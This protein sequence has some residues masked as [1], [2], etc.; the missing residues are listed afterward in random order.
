MEMQ[1]AMKYGRK[2]ISGKGQKAIKYIVSIIF[3]CLCVVSILSTQLSQNNCMIFFP[4]NMIKYNNVF[5]SNLFIVNPA[6]TRLRLSV[7][8]MLR[9]RRRRS[10][11]RESTT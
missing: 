6:I 7:G 2:V 4:S 1:E 10:K 3:S 9:Q 5:F 11:R 8:P